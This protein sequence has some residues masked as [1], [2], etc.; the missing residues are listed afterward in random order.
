MTRG[1]SRKSPKSPRTV[2]KRDITVIHLDS[3][4]E[5]DVD[6]TR[7]VESVQP[8]TV[9][10]V[11]E[12][13]NNDENYPVDASH[14]DMDGVDDSKYNSEEANLGDEEDNN[15]ETNPV[16]DSHGDAD[17]WIAWDRSSKQE[18]LARE[19]IDGNLRR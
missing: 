14:G 2:A 19:R 15:V 10:L 13:D 16:D 9:N 11:D 17:G 8:E 3:D 6:L 7:L 4:D 12:E 5:E 1:A 18:C